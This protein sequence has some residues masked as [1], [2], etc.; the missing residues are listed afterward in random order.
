MLWCGKKENAATS[1][2]QYQIESNP[3][4]NKNTPNSEDQDQLWEAQYYPPVDRPTFSD[5]PTTWENIDL[6][7]MTMTEKLC[8]GVTAIKKHISVNILSIIKYGRHFSFVY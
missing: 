1:K 2:R 7:L 3:I 6:K 4:F 8:Q 5:L